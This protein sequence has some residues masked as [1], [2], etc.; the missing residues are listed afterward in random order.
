MAALIG[1][2]LGMN[3]GWSARESGWNTGMDANL[4]LLD[5]VLQLSVKSRTLAS[6]PTAPANGERYIVASSPT[7]AWAGKAG[8]IAVRLEGAWFFY[9]PK[10]GWTCFIE[11]EDVLS[12]Y[13]ATGWSPGL[14]I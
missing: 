4:K 9:V 8:Q 12:A 2:N 6:P 3:Y 13:K 11:D 1:P 5:A 14:A 7:G 10:I